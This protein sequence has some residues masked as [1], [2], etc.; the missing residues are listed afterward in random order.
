MVVAN[1]SPEEGKGKKKTIEPNRT[2]K[3]FMQRNLWD[4]DGRSPPVGS[5]ISSRRQRL[6]N[7]SLDSTLW[8]FLMLSQS[9]RPLL[10]SPEPTTTYCRMRQLDGF[11]DRS[12]WAGN[13]RF[14]FV[15]YD[16]TVKPQFILSGFP[17][18]WWLGWLFFLK[19]EKK[20]TDGK[21]LS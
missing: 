10:P 18:F 7:V 3:I 12:V 17:L 5:L 11:R 20:H 13:S 6:S 4:S 16:D 9:S 19:T 1:P 15:L 21:I 14:C 2:E 8:F